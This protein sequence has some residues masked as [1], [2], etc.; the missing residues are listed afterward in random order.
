MRQYHSEDSE[1]ISPR[2]R[3]QARGPLGSRTLCAGTNVLAA[4][5]PC[6]VGLL[7]D[8]LPT[9]RCASGKKKDGAGQRTEACCLP[10]VAGFTGKQRVSSFTAFPSAACIGAS[11]QAPALPGRALAIRWMQTTATTTGWFP[12]RAGCIHPSFW[13]PTRRPDFVLRR[14]RLTTFPS[15]SS[16]C[17]HVE[18]ETNPRATV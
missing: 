2:Q 1:L 4:Q 6:P 7:R 15:M 5:R 8:W 12:C 17:S 11:W 10:A 14:S 16:S 9:N 13:I 3:A 18:R